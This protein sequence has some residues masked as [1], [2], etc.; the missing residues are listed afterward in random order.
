MLIKSRI[1]NYEGLVRRKDQ[2]DKLKWESEQNQSPVLL[3][4]SKELSPRKKKASDLSQLD[5]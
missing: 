4:F 1:E 5:Q 2:K 3:T